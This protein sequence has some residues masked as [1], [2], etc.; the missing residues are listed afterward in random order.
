M[1]VILK[2]VSGKLL[3]FI[4]LQL[5]SGVLYCSFVWKL[6]LCLLILFDCVCCLN[7]MKQPFF[8]DLEGAALC[9]CDLYVDC[10]CYICFWLVAEEA[11]VVPVVTWVCCL[12]WAA[13]CPG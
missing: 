4:L 7:Q 3:I 13:L 11:C 12:K 2:P 8:H 6:F 9:R 1:T 5:F 10:L